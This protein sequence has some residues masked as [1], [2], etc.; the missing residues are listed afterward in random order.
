MAWLLLLVAMPV[1]A[2]WQPLGTVGGTT[3]DIVVTDA[4][5]VV[6]S[7]TGA[8]GGAAW[9][10]SDGTL[11]AQLPGDFVG[12]GAFN[13]NCLVGLLLASRTVAFSSVGCGTN[14]ALPGAPTPARFRLTSA[15]G[16]RA[17]RTNVS[18]DGVYSAASPAGPWNSAPNG[19]MWLARA[20]RALGIVRIGTDD[21]TVFNAQ[22]NSIEWMLNDGAPVNTLV[23]YSSY[24]IGRA[25]V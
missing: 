6:T 23:G 17:V 1:Y 13:A 21:F 8:S 10:A 25:H 11:V 22:T 24:E 9:F 4:G 7:S 16:A 5:G 15:G 14:V 20:P 2:G 18:S 19:S 3:Q 12:A